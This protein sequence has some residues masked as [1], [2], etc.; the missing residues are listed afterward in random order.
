MQC[1]QCSC[2]VIQQLLPLQDFNCCTSMA[3]SYPIYV[4]QS[5]SKDRHFLVLK[6]WSL[7]IVF[8]FRR[9]SICVFQVQ[10]HDEGRRF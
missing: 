9:Y 5:G 10:P 2:S 4:L 7:A 3:Q 8:Y 6:V 1:A